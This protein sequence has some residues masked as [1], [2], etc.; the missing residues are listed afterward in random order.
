MPLL[1]L[2]VAVPSPPAAAPL[3][4]IDEGNAQEGEEEAGAHSATSGA[5]LGGS[6]AVPIASADDSDVCNL[7]SLNF[8]RIESLEEL[9][10]VVELGTKFLICGTL[11]AELPYERVYR[12]REKN[13]RRD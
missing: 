3:A 2:V 9:A 8:G 6:N 5:E 4:P 11:R 13:R 12:I 7:G 10:R 1:L